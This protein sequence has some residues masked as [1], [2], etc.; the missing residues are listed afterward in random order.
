MRQRKRQT[1]RSRQEIKESRR[2]IIEGEFRN[3][4]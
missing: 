1:E 3:K 2:G 4:K